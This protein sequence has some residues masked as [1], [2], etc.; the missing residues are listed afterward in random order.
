MKT[1]EE[2]MTVFLAAGFALF[3]AASPSVAKLTV[4]AKGPTP[5]VGLSNG[6][7]NSALKLNEGAVNHCREL[8]QAGHV[9]TDESRASWSEHQPSAEQ[10]NEFIR[11][12]GFE[13]YAKWH[14]G[15]DE[16]HAENTKARYK[17]PYG[18]FR[19]V[20]RCA[21]LAAKSRAGQYKYRDIENA[22]DQIAGLIGR[23][24]KLQEKQ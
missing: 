14:L 23:K 11:L 10:E 6:G 16:E 20:H 1:K 4:D 15:I 9:V 5:A 7:K 12:H 22:A 24:E 18:D 19:N 2:G 8:V 17:F 21:L 3:C 13:E